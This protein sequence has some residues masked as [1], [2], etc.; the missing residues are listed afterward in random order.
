MGKRLRRASLVMGALVSAAVLAATASASTYIRHVPSTGS[1]SFHAD[2]PGSPAFQD[3]EFPG[4]GEGAD[5]DA[6]STAGGRHTT[7]TDRRLTRG[8][9]LSRIVPNTAVTANLGGLALS[10][11]G[12]DHFDTRTASNGNQFS[13][14]PPDQGLCAGN[15]Y[16]METINSA[17]RVYRSNGTPASGVAAF[18]EFYGYPPA[19]NRTTGK[20]GPYMFDPS[21]LY[22]RTT[23][24]WFHLTDTLAQDRNTGDFTGDGW[25]ILPFLRPATHWEPGRSTGSRPPTTERTASRTITVTWGR[26][27]ATT[28]TSARTPTG[29]T[30]PPTSTRSSQTSTPARRSMRSP[31]GSSPRVCM[32][33]RWCISTT[34]GSPVTRASRC[35]LRSPRATTTPGQT[36]PSGS[37]ARW[38]PRRQT[39]R[40]PTS[41]RGLGP[42]QHGIARHRASERGAPQRDPE[43]QPVRRA[44]SVAAATRLDAAAHVPQQHNAG[45]AVRRR[46]LAVV[47]RT[48]RGAAAQPADSVAGFERYPHAAGE[49]GRR[50]PL[51]CARHRRRSVGQPPGR[52]RL[53][54]HPPDDRER[55]VDGS[56]VRQGTLAVAN[57][58]IT[59]PAIG[60]LPNG[61]A[62]M[63][64]TLVGPTTFPSAAWTTLSVAQGTGDVRIA[65]QRCRPAGRVRRLQGVR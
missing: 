2:V 35:G 43:R 34:R 5:P 40:A 47:L 45:N 61:R 18:N 28:R 10:F 62:A 46:L 22:D 32:T 52:N 15:G 57:A 27:S 59:Y 63:T 30:S 9:G 4:G 37:S 60:V 44:T 42:D 58:N 54:R 6:R 49:L 20:F 36:A 56:L 7:V 16:V 29:S 39:A 48:D 19:I 25:S 11:D 3:P 53:V 38:P 17:I 12:L 31:N 13:G 21:C 1:G 33:R 50:R 64:F 26:A 51:G 23:N 24:R 8:L 65:G 14:E 55:R 41:D